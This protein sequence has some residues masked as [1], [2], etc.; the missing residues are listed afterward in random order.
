[1]KKLFSVFLFLTF[2]TLV[3]CT[4]SDFQTDPICAENQTLIESVCV[5]N[6]DIKQDPVCTEDQTL[7]E[8]VCVDNND[9]EQDPVCTENQILVEGVCVDNPELEQDPV[10]TE[11]QTLV[12]GTCVDKEDQD[13][14]CTENQTL[15]EG[16]CIN[17]EDLPPVSILITFET[18]DGTVIDDIL[19]TEGESF[20]MPSD[21][22]KEGYDFKG[23]YTDKYFVSKYK[24][25]SKPS[26]NVEL[27]AKW[28]A[29]FETTVNNYLADLKFNGAA[30]VY[31]DGETL[32]NGG[33]GW[34]NTEL[35]IKNSPETR[36][37]IG[38]VT[39]QFTAVAIMMLY[40]DR[41]INVTDT[42]DMYIPDFPNGDKITI[43]HLLTHTSG[44][45]N[46][47]VL[48]PRDDEY[49]YI[50]KSPLT[51]I[52]LIRYKPLN[53]TPGEKFEYS[54]SNYLMLGYIIELI[55]GVTYQEFM[56]ENIFTPLGM[57]HTGFSTM[58]PGPKDALGYTDI[59]D[60][61][62]TAND[63]RHPSISYSS[64]SMVSTTGDLLIWHNALM[65]YTLLTEQTTN[66]MYTPYTE[67]VEITDGYGYGWYI[68][69]TDDK[70]KLFHSGYSQMF[71]TNFYR[72]TGSDLVVVLTSNEDKNV[73][74]TILYYIFDV[75]TDYG[76]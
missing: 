22:I 14:E 3:G 33:Y 8:G 34:A 10:C 1:M 63:F 52:N 21:P 70:P 50:Y 25:F 15:L 39:K 29:T 28:S 61:T 46:Y 40:E 43:H 51:L 30:L 59:V 56:Q 65:D 57:T 73:L 75:L 13:P 42:L 44:L 17:N 58:K 6:N 37:L 72:N 20:A 19:I 64:G 74:D 45:T 35:Q 41:L 36:F 53:F 26:E 71:S 31:R 69:L 9:I 5:D 62:G 7:V 12:D 27:Y 2:L 4:E 66:L 60:G 16:V 11:D 76:Y 24:Y 48:V 49:R 54:N 18:Y 38:S 47:L 55:T 67:P 32:L 23:W 68:F